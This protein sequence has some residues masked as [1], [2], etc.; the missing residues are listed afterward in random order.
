MSGVAYRRSAELA[1]AVGPYPGW[2]EPGNSEAH[3]AVVRRHCGA[4]REQR[5][6]SADA[7]L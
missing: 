7:D 5:E 3:L 1:A 2:V 4:P 6:G